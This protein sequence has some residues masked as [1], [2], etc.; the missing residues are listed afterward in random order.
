MFPQCCLSHPLPHSAP[1]EAA[2]AAS[3]GARPRPSATLCSFMSLFLYF[4]LIDTASRGTG[5]AAGPGAHHSPGLAPRG[6]GTTLPRSPRASSPPSSRETLQAHAGR[7]PFPRADMAAAQRSVSGARRHRRPSAG[8]AAPRGSGTARAEAGGVC[9]PPRLPM[10]VRRG[11]RVL[12]GASDRGPPPHPTPMVGPAR[13]GGRLKGRQGRALSGPVPLTD[14]G[15]A[16]KCRAK[17]CLAALRPSPSPG[18]FLG[19]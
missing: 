1:G 15:P 12:W 5:P 18:C 13:H 16:P 8:V 11:L 19:I 4:S 9:A 3:G 6:A 10:A 14:T 2:K 7:S 17:P